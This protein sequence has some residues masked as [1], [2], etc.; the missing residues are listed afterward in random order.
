MKK[1]NESLCHSKIKS[2]TGFTLVELMIAVAIV[3][4]L[5]S[6]AYPNYQDYVFR[7]GRSDGKAALLSSAQWMERVM[8][9]SGSYPSAANFPTSMVNSEGGRYTISVVSTNST[10]TLTATKNSN[11][12]GDTC[13]NLTLTHTG[14]RGVTGGSKTADECWGK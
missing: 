2:Q 12:S 9:A 3:G 14:V 6:I 5:A 8:T 4:L 11:Q 13:G 10:F 1:I 7:A